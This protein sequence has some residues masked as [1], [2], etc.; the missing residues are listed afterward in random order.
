MTEECNDLVLL[1]VLGLSGNQEGLWQQKTVGDAD[2][3]IGVVIS[4]SQML[5]ELAQSRHQLMSLGLFL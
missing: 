4:K 1:P 5:S 2:V 3:G